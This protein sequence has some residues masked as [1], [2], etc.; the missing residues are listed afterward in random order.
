MKRVFALIL[1]IFLWLNI[2]P[3]ALAENTILVPCAESSTFVER[4]QN[5][6][7]SYYTTK[8]LKAYSRLLCG[9]D[10]LP[11]LV[12]DRFS[13]ALDVLIPIV[14]FLY[15][16]GWIGWTGRSYLRAIQKLGSQEE[17]EIFIDVPLFVKCMILAFLWPA[18]AVQE[19]LSGDLVNKDEEIPISIR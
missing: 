12:L 4:V 15:I 10:G 9:E 8:P 18:S 19:F 7:D 3:T 1:G 14:I 16:A 13:L 5:A 17:K 2:A 11:H 6:A